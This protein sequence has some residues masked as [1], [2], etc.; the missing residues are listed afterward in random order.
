[1]YYILNGVGSSG[2]GE[3]IR[4][5]GRRVNM[6]KYY[7]LMYENGKMTPVET[8]LRMGVWR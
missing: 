7:V 8:I 3:D 5:R 1:M 6:V 4:K 2:R